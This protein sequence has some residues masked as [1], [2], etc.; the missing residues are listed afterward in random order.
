MEHMFKQT[1]GVCFTKQ[2]MMT[3]LARN[4][5]STILHGLTPYEKTPTSPREREAHFVGNLQYLCHF[6]QANS[7]A[8]KQAC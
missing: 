2:R 6:P 5:D 1:H 7:A 8:K 4:T 3:P